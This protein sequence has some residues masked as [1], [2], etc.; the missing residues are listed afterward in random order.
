MI[1]VLSMSFDVLELGR[2][3]LQHLTSFDAWNPKFELCED[4]EGIN[5]K[6]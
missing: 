3:A 2:V 6:A 1:S 5:I 4:D